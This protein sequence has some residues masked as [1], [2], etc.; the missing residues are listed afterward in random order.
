MELFDLLPKTA[1]VDCSEAM[2][3]VGWAESEDVQYVVGVPVRCLVVVG[4]PVRC[5][6]VV[7][8]PVQCPVVVECWCV[9]PP[10]PMVQRVTCLGL[11][12]HS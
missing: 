1:Q 11:L 8:V 9:D 7:G 10:F 3:E 5:P 2:V 12:V 6:V 4:V